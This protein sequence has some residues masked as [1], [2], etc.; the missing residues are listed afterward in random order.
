[1]E[2]AKLRKVQPEAQSSL[3]A[4]SFLGRSLPSLWLN[5]PRLLRSTAAKRFP[6][7]GPEHEPEPRQFGF[8]H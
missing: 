2:S 6:R 1:M 3:R 7:V 5:P 4:L 8:A